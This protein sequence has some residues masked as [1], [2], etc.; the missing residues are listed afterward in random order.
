VG[1]LVGEIY[2]AAMFATSSG[3]RIAYEVQGAAGGADVLL[4]HAGVNDRRSWEAVVRRL[5]PR[6]RCVAF[7]ARGYGDTA[8][9]REEGWSSVDDAIAVLDAADAKRAVV[10]GC[11][12]GGQTAVDLALSH[13]ERVAALVLIGAG[14]RGAPHELDG[15]DAAL[16]AQIEAAE[17][18]GD[19]DEV[20]RLDA[21]LWLDGA[22]ANEGRVVG[23]PRELFVEMDR[24]AL[25]AD[26][27]GL[28]A[29][30]EPAWPRLDQIA[31]PTLVLIGRL[32]AGYIRAIGES[33]A[34]LIAGARL[35]WLEGVA[36]VPHLEEDPA[37]LDAIATF[38]DEVA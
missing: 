38:L 5:A 29:E 14:I 21:W 24:R 10:V 22:G 32:D 33:A 6:Y 35:Q 20:A 28:P 4:I 31:V 8:Y 7:D 16:G 19:F 34:R 17:S 30:L 37:T 2:I 12:M 27:P 25:A 23:R 13:P 18:R 11:S 1:I 26:D 3:A 36:H 9:D 15:P